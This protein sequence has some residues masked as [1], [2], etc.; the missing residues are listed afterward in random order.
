M[1]A[2]DALGNVPFTIWDGAM[3]SP[4]ELEDDF[5]EREILPIVQ[6]LDPECP[7]AREYL[8]R[9]S[10][11]D[12]VLRKIRPVRRIRCKGCGS[13]EVFYAR[14]DEEARTDLRGRG[15]ARDDMCP[16]CMWRAPLLGRLSVQ[17]FKER[18]SL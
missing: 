1:A 5:F 6:A 7:D 2:A 10:L 12:L 3:V 11:A 4:A 13:W 8:G 14:S 9:R 18:K 15:W 17:W 16:D